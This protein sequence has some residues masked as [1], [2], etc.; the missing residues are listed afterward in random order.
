MRSDIKPRFGKTRQSGSKHYF[1]VQVSLD[2]GQRFT[3]A[4]VMKRD[5]RDGR[6]GTN[7]VPYRVEWAATG[8]LE[9]EA[10]AVLGGLELKCSA[11]HNKAELSKFLKRV[12]RRYVPAD[13]EVPVDLGG[14]H[15]QGS[16]EVR[17]SVRPP[18]AMGAGT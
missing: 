4:L 6:G 8:E 7:D 17:R 13:V 16:V 3:D 5:D 9:R 15:C 11:K 12:P 18:G 2:G 10:K 1:R 14:A